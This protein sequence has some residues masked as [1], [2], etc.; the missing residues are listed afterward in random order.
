MKRPSPKS[1]RSNKYSDNSVFW[2]YVEKPKD[3]WKWEIVLN[4]QER[5]ELYGFEMGLIH[6]LHLMA[7]LIYIFPVLNLNNFYILR[8]GSSVHHRC[9]LGKHLLRWFYQI[10]QMMMWWLWSETKQEHWN[11]PVNFDCSCSATWMGLQGFPLSCHKA[12]DLLR[13]YPKLPVLVC[14]R[15]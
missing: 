4:S 13:L 8:L 7:S 2:S 10:L 3:E 14:L 11:A 1:C 9:W 5:K 12:T 6:H 15:L